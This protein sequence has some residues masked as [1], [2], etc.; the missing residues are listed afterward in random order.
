MKALLEWPKSARGACFA[1]G[2]AL[3]VFLSWYI[4]SPVQARPGVGLDASHMWTLAWAHEEGKA[5]GSEILFTYGPLG[6]LRGQLLVPEAGWSSLALAY[7]YYA[8][9]GFLLWRSLQPAERP[10]VAAMALSLLLVAFYLTWGMAY[11]AAVF[12]ILLAGG[13]FLLSG[14]ARV[15]GSTLCFLLFCALNFYVKYTFSLLV[16]ILAAI[17]AVSALRERTHRW[18]L[19]LLVAALVLAGAF[20]K[21]TP[22]SIFEYMVNTWPLASGYAAAMSIWGPPSEWILFLLILGSAQSIFL[23]SNYARVCTIPFWRAYLWVSLIC[24]FAWKLSFVRHD[25]HALTAASFL[26][27]LTLFFVKEHIVRYRSSRVPAQLLLTTSFTFWSAVSLVYGYHLLREYEPSGT[28][29]DQWARHW[30]GIPGKAWNRIVLPLDRNALKAEWE[31]EVRNL[32]ATQPLPQKVEGTVDFYNAYSG[33]VLSHG[34]DYTP[35][36]IFQSYSAYTPDLIRRNRDHLTG[37][38]A[39]DYLVT[40]LLAIDRR[41]GT[42]ADGLSWLEIFRR[43]APVSKEERLLLWERVPEDAQGG[44]DLQL[45]A[46]GAASMGEEV[47]LDVAQ[48]A[49]LWIEIEFKERVIGRLQDKLFKPSS[50]FLEARL[51]R[52]GAVRRRLVP[53]M[54]E[55]GF[56]LSPVVENPDQLLVFLAGAPTGGRFN[57]DVVSFHLRERAYLLRN[58]KVEYS[59]RIYSLD[60]SGTPMM[61]RTFLEDYMEELNRVL[62]P[63]EGLMA[64][65]ADYLPEVL[66]TRELGF[67]VFAHAPTRFVVPNRFGDRLIR[68]A[69]G[70]YDGS[71]QQGQTDGAGFRV[72]GL[73]SPDSTSGELIFSR[74]L[75]PLEDTDA[76]GMQ[77]SELSVPPDYDYLLFE[78]D[79]LENPDWD[80][81]YWGAIVLP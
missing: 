70:L 12:F 4:F 78:T 26:V 39:P 53:G 46:S 40:D 30:T 19:A 45:I 16:L 65:E 15:S 22:Y 20:A 28:L 17:L 1:L 64:L 72:S 31:S 24:F 47:R 8:L 36:P 54:T 48:G 51:G 79:P 37:E 41:W 23:A 18:T 5:W 77:W 81:S 76:R 6:Y 56:L 59:Y 44:A 63:Y 68:V 58:Y 55:T 2:V 49:P 75:R 42:L 66:Q 61:A 11:D 74:D 13:Y 43:Y 33:I 67:H 9:L 71:W 35:R 7:L 60:L 52:G 73:S 29:R 50:L 38:H 27:L 69:F 25:G 57:H 34:L 10:G 21:V 80:W 62:R 32:K 3:S 14:N